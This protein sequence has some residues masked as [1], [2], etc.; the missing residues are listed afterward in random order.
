ML[1]PKQ[2]FARINRGII[3]DVTVLLVNTLLM[4]VLSGRL[5]A[6]FKAREAK[7]PAA[8]V[9]TFFYLAGL[10]ILPG[11]AA[12]LKFFAGNRFTPGEYR[13]A[14]SEFFP[15]ILGAILVG[16]FILNAIFIFALFETRDDLIEQTGGTALVSNLFLAIIG[17]AAVTI[18]IYPIFTYCHFFVGTSTL[19]P[20][21]FRFISEILA[22]LCIFANVILYQAF[23]GLLMNDLPHDIHNIVGRLGQFLFSAALIY[24]PPR[25][26]YLADD[27]GR[28]ITWIMILLANSPVLIRIFF[29]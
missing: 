13:E 25:I 4:T 27:G 24:I 20:S 9:T 11:V 10:C 3:L 18:V 29:F 6:L 1:R 21:R 2:I 7:D 14:A 23:W 22:D 8:E 17:V 16:Q 28:W 19:R 5:A 12:L 26:Y 15:N